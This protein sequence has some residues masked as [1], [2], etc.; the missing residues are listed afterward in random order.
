MLYFL[1]LVGS[2]QDD[3]GRV[4]DL[5]LRA[6][7]IT[8]CG[9]DRTKR[10]VSA[11]IP[12]LL[13]QTCALSQSSHTCAPRGT[14]DALEGALVR[15]GPATAN[16]TLVGVASTRCMQPRPPR[17][18]RSALGPRPAGRSRIRKGQSL[19]EE[20]EIGASDVIWRVA[21]EELGA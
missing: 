16:R 19:Q 12:V 7:L 13:T 17:E 2:L 3:H 15:L 6:G 9:R 18:C 14:T 10:Y 11:R 1:M 20:R 4:V 21:H 5:G 8:N